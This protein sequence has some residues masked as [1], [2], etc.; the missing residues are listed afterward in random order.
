MSKFNFSKFNSTNSKFDIDSSEFRVN[1]KT[2]K[3]YFKLAEMVEEYGEDVMFQVTGLYINK[4]SAYDAETPV[5]ATTME[6]VNVPVFQLA[7][8]KAMIADDEA[9]EAINAGECG[10]TI[11][12]YDHP[13]YG[14]QLKVVWCAYEPD[15]E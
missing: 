13:D 11:E 4:K 10:F 6:F 3:P 9:V 8:V 14:K 12:A 15:E 1:P 2:G 7:E 5:V